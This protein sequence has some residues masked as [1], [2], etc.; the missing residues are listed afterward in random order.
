MPIGPGPHMDWPAERRGILVFLQNAIDVVIAH[1]DKSLDTTLSH[2]ARHMERTRQQLR[3]AR[4]RYFT[5]SGQTP[6]NDLLS[7]KVR[8]AALET[9]LNEVSVAFNN[10]ITRLE[11]KE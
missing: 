9:S 6:P 1:P 11:D 10:R 2:L 4:E 8:I 5:S 3:D 7:L